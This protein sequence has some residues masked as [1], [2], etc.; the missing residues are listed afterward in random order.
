MINPFRLSNTTAWVMLWAILP[1][2]PAMAI[3][4]AAAHRTEV[5]I[6]ATFDGVIEAVN[7][8]TVSAETSGQ[9]Q[10][11]LFDTDDFVH[12]NDII[13][14]LRDIAQQARL[15]QAEQGLQEAR[16]RFTEASANF[17]RNRKLLTEKTISKAVYDKAEAD[18]KA[19]SARVSSAEAAVAEAQD[20]LE[21]TLVR[22]PYSGIVV[23]RL[24]EVG[25]VVQPGTPLMSGLSLDQLRASTQIPERLIGTVREF[26][27]AYVHLPGS[28]NETLKSEDMDIS[29][30]AH[31]Q[32]HT[33]EVRVNL[34]EAV[35][36]LYP[37]MSVKVAIVTG[38]TNKL[39]V[40]ERAILHRSEVTGVYVVDKGRVSL[41]QVRIGR[42]YG[43]DGG[44]HEREVLAGLENG[45]Q[46]ALDPVAAGIALKQQ[47]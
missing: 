20:L 25:A 41:R 3:E 29:P 46:V 17:E 2:Q 40:P 22:A 34:P 47:H 5:T 42:T 45:E 28:D 13:V 15:K 24:V 9:V 39:L 26:H 19:A 43:N 14:R 11:I 35:A 38:K 37:G 10:A 18:K 7:Q 30:R 27:T 12:R 33:F 44:D 16:A 4:T 8:T 32:T 36:G 31:P 6:E 23:E 1:I 21:R